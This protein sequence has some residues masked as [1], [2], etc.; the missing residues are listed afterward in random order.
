MFIIF[1]K[2]HQGNWPCPLEAMLFNQSLN[3]LK[4][5]YVEG[6]CQVILKSDKPVPRRILMKLP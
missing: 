4:F 3:L 6:F 1:T 5:F 2:V